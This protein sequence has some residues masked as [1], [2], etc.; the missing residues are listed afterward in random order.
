MG[1]PTHVYTIG[2]V[3]VLIGENL[4]LIQEIAAT[5]T[6]STMAR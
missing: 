2:Y 4:E 5:P 3:A 1:R 6:I